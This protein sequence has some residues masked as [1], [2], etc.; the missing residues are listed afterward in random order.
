MGVLGAFL[1]NQKSETGAAT[2]ATPATL[3]PDTP[4]K[5]QLSQ[6]SQGAD[7]E[8]HFYGCDEVA[9]AQSQAF[10]NRMNREAEDAGLTS[11]WCAC[12]SLASTAWH[13]AGRQTWR[14]DDCGHPDDA[15]PPAAASRKQKNPAKAA[16]PVIKIDS[17]WTPDPA[18]EPSMEWWT[19]PVEGWAD[20]R[21]VIRNMA[22]AAITDVDLKSGEA[23][24]AKGG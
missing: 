6:L 13:V 22:E 18:P 24:R 23:R 2:V 16:K 19:A 14:C 8:I 21:L 10:A 12:G 20:G 9:P 11:R 7:P 3:Q 4:E 15:D 1:K 17:K 5:S